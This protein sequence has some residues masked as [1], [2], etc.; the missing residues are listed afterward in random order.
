MAKKTLFLAIFI[1][2]SLFC[3]LGFT[4]AKGYAALTQVES[5]D[6]PAPDS[7]RV[8][9]IGGYFMSLKWRPVAG[10]NAYFL[11][12]SQLDSAGNL[13]PNQVFPN[14]TD[15]LITVYGLEGG[16]KYQL[17]LSSK[18]SN[19]D[20]SSLTA[21]IDG[22]TLIVDLTL[23]GRIPDK[24]YVIS[25]SG[26]PYQSLNWLGFRVTG[27]GASGLFEVKVNDLGFEPLAWIK[28]VYLADNIVATNSNGLF[29]NPL[30][31]IYQDVDIP[32]R[33]ENILLTDPV[34]GKVDI[35]KFESPTGLKMVKIEKASTNP[36]WKSQYALT[37]LAADKVISPDEGGTN[38]GLV[39]ND[40]NKFI[41][42][43]SPFTDH[44][45]LKI[46]DSE[47]LVNK[48]SFFIFDGVG[49]LVSTGTLN[50]ADANHRVQTHNWSN[51]I[52]YLI[53]NSGQER[54]VLKVIK[55]GF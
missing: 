36:P 2:F 1:A 23:G 3:N 7:F 15:T 33:I 18:C 38:Q 39:M 10:V 26:I 52:Y 17:K 5:C 27:E 40:G 44:L 50:V 55:A 6:A 25:G 51:G 35:A 37:V 14:I 43:A 42:A 12:V 47:L 54:T 19:G 32:F 53:C 16:K 20:V 49:Q 41:S 46:N 34:I 4:E 22:I 45:E 28:R 13:I 11:L 24:P 29:P 48:V 21:I 31:P 8:T 30:N 9:G